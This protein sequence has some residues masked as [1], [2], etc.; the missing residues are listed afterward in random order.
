MN[1]IKDHSEKD[2][3]RN[4]S[5]NQ[6]GYSLASRLA[7]DAQDLVDHYERLMTGE[8]I[9]DGDHWDYPLGK[10]TDLEPVSYTHLTLPTTP[11]V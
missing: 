2:M 10:I 8:V 5:V 4:D 1:R 9:G 6:W 11:Y 7:L 3:D